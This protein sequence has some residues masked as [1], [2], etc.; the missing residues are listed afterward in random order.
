MFSEIKR[1]VEQQKKKKQIN[2][3]STIFL[4]ASKGNINKMEKQPTKWKKLFANYLSDKR[5]ISRIYKEVLQLNN[6]KQ[7]IQFKNGQMT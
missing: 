6:K 5:L 7:I 1:N 2:K 3:T 4:S